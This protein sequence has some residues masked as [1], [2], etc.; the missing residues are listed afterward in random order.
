MRGTEPIKALGQEVSAALISFFMGGPPPRGY[1]SLVGGIARRAGCYM[2]IYLAPLVG[3]GWAYLRLPSAFLPNE[4]QGFL[5]V[6]PHA[7]GDGAGRRR[8]PFTLHRS[9]QTK[10]QSTR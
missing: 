5:L 10:P 8:P 7:A 9:T 6:R 1:S 2:M 4:D 3:L